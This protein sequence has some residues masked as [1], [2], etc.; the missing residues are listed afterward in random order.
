[1]GPKDLQFTQF[2]LVSETGDGQPPATPPA[3]NNGD[4]VPLLVDE[5]G[6]PWVRIAG[7][8]MPASQVSVIPT[9][10]PDEELSVFSG[11]GTAAVVKAQ[12]GRLYSLTAADAETN[13]YIHIFNKAAA[14]IA[15]DV[16]L[17]VLGRVS[18]PGDASLH[19][20]YQPIGIPFSA[21]I[22]VGGSTTLSPF[23]PTGAPGSYR[24]FCAY[25]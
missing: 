15:G 18:T 5:Y 22:A 16:P 13:S 10:N 4:G 21:G 25:F 9:A 19:A 23:T 6:R 12:A 20:S 17:I 11:N 3:A 14:P 8:A 1:M 2:A 7:D 24:I